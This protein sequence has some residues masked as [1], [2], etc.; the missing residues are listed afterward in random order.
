MSDDTKREFQSDR[1]GFMSVLGLLP[2]YELA[3]I[4]AAY[5][6]KALVAHPDRGGDPA[7]FMRLKD[8]Y[9][10]AVDYFNYNGSRREWIAGQVEQYLRQEEVIAEVLRRGGRVEIERLDWIENSWGEGLSHLAERLRHIYVRNMRDGDNFLEFLSVQRPSYLVGIDVSGSR[11]SGDGLS[12]LVDFETLRWLDVS[13]TD[14]DRQSVETLLSR[15]ESLEWL[16]VRKT[17]LG[18][19]GRWQLRRAHS[20]R[21]VT[22]ISPAVNPGNETIQSRLSP[23]QV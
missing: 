21:V 22:E 11:I 16:N 9:D 17:Q 15:L 6:S 4:K 2:P 7:D 14:V 10:H 23:W 1:P 20:C 3:D 19:L 8:A 18:L 5:H 13:D 12:S